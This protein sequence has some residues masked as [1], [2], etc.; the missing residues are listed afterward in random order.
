MEKQNVYFD[1]PSIGVLIIKGH[2]S[3]VR[4]SPTL[5]RLLV[6]NKE[7][8]KDKVN[9]GFSRP[10]KSIDYNAIRQTQSNMF[11]K[12]ALLQHDS[13]YNS[14]SNMPTIF[15]KGPMANSQLLA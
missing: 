14:T 2:K 1:I 12:E 5:V 8:L 11:S 3:C 6:K 4:F 9:H 13:N 10:S 15:A 7:H